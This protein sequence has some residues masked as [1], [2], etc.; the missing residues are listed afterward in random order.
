M[1]SYKA[2]ES[3][4]PLNIAIVGAG[5]GGLAAAIALRR[6]GHLVQVHKFHALILLPS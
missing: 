4:H 5:I 6:N 1:A 3:T 2:S